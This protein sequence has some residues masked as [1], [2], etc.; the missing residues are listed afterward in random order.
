MRKAVSTF[1]FWCSLV[2][3]GIL[4]VPAAI[5]IGMIYLIWNS[6][7]FVIRKLDNEQ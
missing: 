6:A 2:P 7:D 5:L 4:A 1:L 3:I